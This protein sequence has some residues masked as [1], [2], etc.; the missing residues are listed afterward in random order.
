VRYCTYT[1][2]HSNVIFTLPL[3]VTSPECHFPSD[4]TCF[5]NKCYDSI[6]IGKRIEW[7]AQ[8][9]KNPCTSLYNTKQKTEKTA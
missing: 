5:S 8:L 3:N 1:L 9:H 6:S 2:I 4:C 7:L